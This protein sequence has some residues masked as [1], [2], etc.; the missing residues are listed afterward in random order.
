VNGP[1]LLA[2]AHGSRDPA[3]A[4]TTAALIRQVERLAPVLDVQL[5]FVQHAEPTLA[6]AL[7][8]AGPDVVIVPLL[9][10]SGY[11][12]TT[13]IRGAV[14]GA[15]TAA[16]PGQSS[17][18]VAGPLGPD[19]LLVTALVSRLAQAGVPN[20]THVVLAAAGSSDP[21]AAVEVQ[22]QADLLAAE[23]GTPVVAA[24]AAAGSPTVPAAVAELRARTTGPIAVA[25]YLLA[26]GQFHDDLAAS[27]ADWVTE[28]LGDHPAVAALIIDR[29]RTHARLPEPREPVTIGT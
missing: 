9:L 13:D 14:A 15:V 29:Y 7:D 27:C 22:G 8:A 12:L 17:P 24:F 19:P 20:G 11:H 26:P 3:A 2:V 5:A 6:D 16:V 25:T 4:T 1:T 18:R 21:R 23:L 10:S 28:P